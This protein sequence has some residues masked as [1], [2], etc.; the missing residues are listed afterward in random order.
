MP[1][2]IGSRERA[3]GWIINGRSHN[4]EAWVAAWAA[5]QAAAQGGEWRPAWRRAIVRKRAHDRELRSAVRE[6][7][8]KPRAFTA[9]A[10]YRRAA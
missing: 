7:A 4:D 2:P 5:V 6:L 3:E 9:A 10:T 1:M 8:R